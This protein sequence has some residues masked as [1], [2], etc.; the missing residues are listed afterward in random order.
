MA[1]QGQTPSQNEVL[2]IGREYA[3]GGEESKIE[4]RELIEEPKRIEEA[5]QSKQQQHDPAGLGDGAKSS[6]MNGP[7]MSSGTNPNDFSNTMNLNTCFNNGMDYNQMMQIMSG[8]MGTGMANFNP[9][10]GKSDMMLLA[11]TVPIIP[12][13]NVQYGYGSNAGYVWEYGWPRNGHDRSKRHERGYEYE[14][15]P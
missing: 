9:M 2:S 12:T 10:M 3:A 6:K 8:N 7:V 15:Q 14:F 11:Q 5:G 4:S 1:N 13:R